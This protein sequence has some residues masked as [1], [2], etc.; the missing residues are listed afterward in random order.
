MAIGTGEIKALGTITGWAGIIKGLVVAGGK[1][2]D[3]GAGA[4]GIETGTGTGPEFGSDTGTTG[5]I[6]DGLA[7]N[8]TLGVDTVGAK[9]G[10]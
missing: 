9:S 7:D 10:A 6:S 3:V 8:V 5:I 1:I 4:G 2:T